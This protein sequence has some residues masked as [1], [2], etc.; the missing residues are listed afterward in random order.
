MSIY[1]RIQSAS[2][3]K[4]ETIKSKQEKQT[5]KINRISD[6]IEVGLVTKL[7]RSEDISL[8]LKQ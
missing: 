3:Q 2:D 4:F 1:K 7:V 6:A 5:K 8:G